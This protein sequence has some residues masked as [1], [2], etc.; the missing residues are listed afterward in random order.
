M[1]R[2]LTRMYGYRLFRPGYSAPYSRTRNIM[3]E[4]CLVWF[5]AERT[6]TITFEARLFCFLLIERGIL[7]L[8]RAK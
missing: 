1:K 8:M 4:G 5:M 7:H 2:S 3:F 6:R